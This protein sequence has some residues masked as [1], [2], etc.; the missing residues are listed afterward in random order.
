MAEA[1]VT[2]QRPILALVNDLFFTL[3]IGD[4]AK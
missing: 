4:S 1:T 2:L 3:K